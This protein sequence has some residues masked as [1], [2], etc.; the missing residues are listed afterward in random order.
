M[1]VAQAS[2]GLIIILYYWSCLGYINATNGNIVDVL[3]AGNL[4]K[5]GNGNDI[6]EMHDMRKS[7]CIAFTDDKKSIKR[8][9]VMKIAMLYSKDCNRLI[10]NFPNDASIG[11]DG[12]IN[13]GT[14]STSLGLIMACNVWLKIT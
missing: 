5:N 12:Q 1:G 4:T 2:I 6:V 13:E 10:M 11:S 14:I 9:E 7:G 3:P 8:N